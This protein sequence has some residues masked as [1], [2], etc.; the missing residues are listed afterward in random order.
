M[1]LLALI[2]LLALLL[3]LLLALLLILLLALLLI[4]LLVLLLLLALILLLV[5]LLLVALLLLVLFLLL[6]F[7]QF[8]QQFQIF[9][10]IRL[11]RLQLQRFFIGGNRLIQLPSPGEGVAAVVQAVGVLCVG[12]LFHGGFVIAALVCRRTGPIGIP[13]Q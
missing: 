6:L 7:F 13:E 4:L 9:A 1:L 12:E 2:L 8:L 3:I 10:G 5:L 11:L